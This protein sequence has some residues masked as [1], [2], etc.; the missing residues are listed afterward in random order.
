MKHSRHTRLGWITVAA[1]TAAALF[2]LSEAWGQSTGAAAVFEGR[3]A[4]SGAQAGQGPMAGPPQGGISPQGTDGS[5]GVTLRKP[6]GLDAMPAVPRDPGV[7]R[8][9]PRDS[10]MERAGATGELRPQR[11]RDPGNVTKQNRAS[12]KAKRAAKRAVQRTRDVADQ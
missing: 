3:P 10:G 2:T 8:G 6:T 4:M 1:V 12:G 7:D 9:N 5:P 11:D